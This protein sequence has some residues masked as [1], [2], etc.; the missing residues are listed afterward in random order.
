MDVR[1]RGNGK[2]RRKAQ[3]ERKDRYDDER[4]APSLPTHSKII[5]K[6][7]LAVNHIPSLSLTIL[8][9]GTNLQMTMVITTLDTLRHSLVANEGTNNSDTVP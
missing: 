6:S 5:G 2:P 8:H 7:H 1:V 9:E 4:I 3:R